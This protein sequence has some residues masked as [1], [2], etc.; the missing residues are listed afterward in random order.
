MGKKQLPL[1]VLSRADLFA[2]VPHEDLPEALACMSARIA[3]YDAGEI[4]FLAGDEVPGV[5]VVCDGEVQVVRE[6]VFGNRTIL[7]KLGASEIF[8][9]TFACARAEHARHVK[10]LP[11]SVIATTPAE[12]ALFD[13]QKV[14]ASPTSSCPFHDKLIEN[15]LGILA[16]KNLML[17]RKI[18][19]LSVRTTRAKLLTY[20]SSQAQRA[21]SARFKIPF[22]R[23]ELADYLAVDR[24]AMSAELGRMQGDGLIRFKRNEFE[25][26]GVERKKTPR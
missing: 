22:N 7:A 23:Q 14:V 26:L 2:G 20:L 10:I 8:G 13:F 18:E 1:D 12:I 25:L 5:G 19:V 6:D 11:V 16:E 17:N 24:S 15:M 9:E 4:V 21:C 3:T